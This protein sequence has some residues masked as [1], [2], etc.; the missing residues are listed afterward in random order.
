MN[1]DHVVFMLLSLYVYIY[2]KWIDNHRPFF[3]ATSMP[4]KV[5]KVNL[6][7]V[8]KTLI[9]DWCLEKWPRFFQGPENSVNLI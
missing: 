9:L 2:K 5:Q 4:Q 3:I 6:F 8:I 7:Y 1:I